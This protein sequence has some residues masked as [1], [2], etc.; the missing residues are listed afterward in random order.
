MTQPFVA[1]ILEPA[2]SLASVLAKK[3]RE[4][5]EHRRLRVGGRFPTD[6]EI[7]KAFGVS[8]TVVREAVSSLREAGLISTQRGRGSIVIAYATSPGFAVAGEELESG[9]RLLQLY[10]FRT[11][12]EAEA[13]GMAA[14]KRNDEDIERLY[15]CLKTG[16]EA[17]TF[18]DVIDADIAFH[19]AIAQATH[20]EYFLRIMATIR[21]AT[22]A[23]ALLRYD[24]DEAGY[25]ELYQAVVQK[26]HRLIADAVKAGKSTESKR[27][28]KR[29]LGGRRYNALVKAV[30]QKDV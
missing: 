29:H 2:P 7:A 10:E 4:E 20:N 15:A 27:L 11:L 30:G 16:D 26:E 6:A 18:E 28:L 23:R 25:V 3:L 22:T 14:L 1:E 13:A 5:I 17:K 9:E 19:V 24:L 12:I 21:T 8:R